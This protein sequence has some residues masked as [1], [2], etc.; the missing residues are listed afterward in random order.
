[1]D[2]DFDIGHSRRQ[3]AWLGGGNHTIINL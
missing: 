1:V 3:H 2:G